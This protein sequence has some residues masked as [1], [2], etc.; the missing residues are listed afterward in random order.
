MKVKRGGPLRSEVE[1]AFWL[2]PKGRAGTRRLITGYTKVKQTYTP[3][4]SLVVNYTGRPV[5]D[6]KEDNKQQKFHNVFNHA[7]LLL[8]IYI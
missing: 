1:W 7:I 6:K 4:A 5:R 2:F 8:L 3:L